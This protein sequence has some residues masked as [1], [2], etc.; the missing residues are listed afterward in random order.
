ML[1]NLNFQ[2]LQV[3]NLHLDV[4]DTKLQQSLTSST[5]S[6]TVLPFHSTP[7][8]FES[9][10]GDEKSI[11]S[12]SATVGTFLVN[13]LIVSLSSNISKLVESFPFDYKPKDGVQDTPITYLAQLK[14]LKTKFNQHESSI[15]SLQEEI[16]GL[17]KQLNKVSL[18]LFI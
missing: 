14:H 1:I 7:A 16:L 5:L 15:F 2:H 13:A 4:I 18:C 6:E 8:S 10:L 12:N 9:L 11:T 3:A 17:C